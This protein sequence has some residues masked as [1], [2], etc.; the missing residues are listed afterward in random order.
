MDGMAM[1]E[2]EVLENYCNGLLAVSEFEDFCPN[3]TQLDAGGGPVQRI[4]SAVTA[5]Q[6]AIDGAAELDADLLLVHHG[7]FWRGEPASLVGLKGRRVGSL[8][9][10]GI[11]LMAYH[12]PLD[13]HPQLGNNRL[14]AQRLG[15]ADSAPAV[16]EGGLLWHTILDT[17][18]SAAALTERIRRALDRDPLHLP[19]GGSESI[20]RLGWCSGAAQEKIVQAAALGLDAFISGEASEQTFHQAR[21]LGIHYFAA[22]H[23]ATERFGVQALGE[24]LAEKFGLFHQFLDVSNPV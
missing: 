21:E 1:V 18:E 23:H 8:Y 17:P 9:R 4:V 13:A 19:G 12:L 5:S 24:H 11:S 7:Y 2:L 20:R 10:R 6:A 22:G 15:L 3:G 16:E 14:L